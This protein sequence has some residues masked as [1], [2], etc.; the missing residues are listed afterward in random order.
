MRDSSSSSYSSQSSTY[1]PP[2]NC[3]ACQSRAILTTT[4]SPDADSY[5]R[6]K[7]CGEVW[8]ESR[9]ETSRQGARRWRS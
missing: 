1:A 6:C 7:D 3:P 2:S 9:S 5:W 8:N 4:K